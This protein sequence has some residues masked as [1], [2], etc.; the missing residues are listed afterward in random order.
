LRLFFYTQVVDQSLAL[1]V[2]KEQI[3]PEVAICGVQGS[4]GIFGL[5]LGSFK[6][7][8]E[9]SGLMT[10]KK[11]FQDSGSLVFTCFILLFKN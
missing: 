2:E 5:L 1:F 11:T 10:L 3:N 6:G 7:D 4:N 9:T 8:I